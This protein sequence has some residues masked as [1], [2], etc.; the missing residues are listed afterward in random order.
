MIHMPATL[1]EFRTMSSSWEWIAGSYADEDKRQA[2]RIGAALMLQEAMELHPFV[3]SVAW[4][5]L[6]EPAQAIM[7]TPTGPCL[8]INAL[9]VIISGPRSEAL[10]R[11]GRCLLSELEAM[12]LDAPRLRAAHESFAHA[13]RLLLDLLEPSERQALQGEGASFHAREARSIASQLGLDELAA[14]ILR[15]QIAPSARTADSRPTPSR[16]L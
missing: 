8:V 3:S 9:K 14:Q 15:A 16:S 10:P 12:G 2:R 4:P 11:Q 7:E 6:H 5:S 13:S 1:D